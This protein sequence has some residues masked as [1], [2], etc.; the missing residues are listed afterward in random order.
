[1]DMLKEQR[2]IE[3]A[4]KGNQK[5]FTALF[6]KYKNHIQYFVYLK[7]HNITT[8]E[9]LT[10]EILSKALCNINKYTPTD[11][12]KFSTWLFRIANNHCID[13]IKARYCRPNLISTTEEQ[14]K[15]ISEIVDSKYANPEQIMISNQESERIIKHVD[16]LNPSYGKSLIMYSFEE[17]QYDEIAKKLG[18]TISSVSGKVRLA[19]RAL[20]IK[21]N[22]NKI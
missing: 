12:A 14:I 10:I 17:M 22:K 18:I 8:A 4:K 20:S 1:M 3:E 2:L 15:A 16:N 6:N 11:T 7:I 19:R 13:F 21:L 5:A 9:D